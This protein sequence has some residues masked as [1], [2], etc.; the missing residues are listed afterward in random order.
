MCLRSLPCLW[1]GHGLQRAIR[2]AVEDRGGVSRRGGRGRLGG[3][4][5]AGRDAE[6]GMGALAADPYDANALYA[7]GRFSL[8]GQVYGLARYLL[9]PCSGSGRGWCR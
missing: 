5:A 1:E 9:M 7:Y 4:T 8:R 3:N 2:G 6:A